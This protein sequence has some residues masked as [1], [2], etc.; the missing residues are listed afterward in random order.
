MAQQGAGHQGARAEARRAAGA[1]RGTGRIIVARRAAD[2]GAKEG[3]AQ[4]N[5]PRESIGSHGRGAYLYT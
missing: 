4:N 1:W 3:S 5:R 2:D